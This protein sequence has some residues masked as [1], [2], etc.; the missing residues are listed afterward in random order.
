MKNKYLILGLLWFVIVAWIFWYKSYVDLQDKQKQIEK[1]NKIEREK[2]DKEI[3]RNLETL[4]VAPVL[5]GSTSDTWV[6][7]DEKK[8]KQEILENEKMSIL[9]FSSISEC[10]N[11][12]YLKDKCKDTFLYSLAEKKNDLEYCERL[13]NPTDVNNCK[14][15]INYNNSKCEVIIDLALKAKCEHNAKQAKMYQQK[16]TILASN[17]IS[18][19]DACKTLTAYSEKETCLKKLVLKNKDMSLCGKFFTSK[20]EQSKCYK[21]IAYDFN[22]AL[23]TEAFEKKDLT[24]CEKITDTSVKSQCKSMKF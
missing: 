18:S 9:T 23:I 8:S 4:K 24:L 7:K 15:E 14:D 11:L 17:D 21:N 12:T 20:D 16:E 1:R 13:K 3:E 6:K 10:D 22:R 5:S 2:K 19:S